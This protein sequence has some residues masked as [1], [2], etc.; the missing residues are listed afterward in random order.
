MA[1]QASFNFVQD[2]S[3]IYELSFDEE[4]SKYIMIF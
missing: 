4:T 3:S 2:N 1:L